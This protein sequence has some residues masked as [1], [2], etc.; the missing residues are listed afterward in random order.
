MAGQLS[1]WLV[2][3]NVP[4]LGQVDYFTYESKTSKAGKP[5]LRFKRNG[6]EY[7]GKPFKIVGV[8]Q[9]HEYSDQYQNLSFNITVEAQDGAVPAPQGQTN[10]P[11]GG[12]SKK[13]A[14]IDRAV[15]FKAAVELIAGTKGVGEQGPNVE[16]TVENVRN[17]TEALL[18][19]VTG[20]SA[21]PKGQ[22]APE[23][24]APE[25]VPMQQPGPVPTTDDDIPF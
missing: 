15:A 22:E 24:I 25:Q 19:V 8:Q 6:P 1:G 13:D 5:Y 7:N 23:Q 10:I 21:D 4:Q 14:K 16:V 12:P 18:P 20:E 11:N 3:K 2:A 9:N 17:L